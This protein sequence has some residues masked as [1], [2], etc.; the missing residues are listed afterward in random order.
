MDQAIGTVATTGN[1][2]AG[3]RDPDADVDNIAHPQSQTP[4][5]EADDGQ[6]KLITLAVDNMHCGGCMRSIERALAALPSVVSARANL[7]QRRVVITTSQPQDIDTFIG[8]LHSEGFSA[9]AIVGHQ[10]EPMQDRMADLSRRLGVAAFATMNVML[11][12]VSVWSGT[13]GDMNPAVQ[14]L[15]HWLSALIALPTIVY[16]GQPFF[17][18]AFTALSHGRVNMDVPIAIGVFLTAALSLYQTQIHGDQVYFDAALMLLTF[19]LMGRLLDQFVRSRAANAASNLLKLRHNTVTAVQADGSH[20][21]LAL[22]DV[23]PGLKVLVAVG[24]RIS[25]DGR[26]VSGKSDVDQSLITGES[27]P[28]PVSENGSVFAGTLNL[29]GPLVVEVTAREDQSVLAEIATLLANAEQQRGR[30]VDIADRAARYYAPF[31]H[32][33][34]AATFIG[35]W[36]AAADWQSA[37]P[38][39]IS[40][41][42]ITCPCALALAVPAVQVAASGALLKSGIILKSPDAL[43]RLADCT[44]LVYDKT[45][46]LTHGLPSL[47]DKHRYSDA[48]I[49][50]V[51]ALA[52]ASTHPYAQALVAEARARNLAV[53]LAPDVTEEPGIGLSAGTGTNQKRLCNPRALPQALQPRQ[54][55]SASTVAFQT[56]SLDVIFFQFEDS[57][58]AD[59]ADTVQ[60]LKQNGYT[61]E[62]LSGDNESGVRAVADHLPIDRW[63]GDQTPAEK[64]QYLDHLKQQNQTVAMIGDG[65]NDA[66]SLAS[67]HA[68]MSPASASH[69]SQVAADIVFQG[70]KLMPVAFTLSTAKFAQKLVRQNFALAIGYNIVFVPLAMLGWVTPLVAAI[71]M[72]LSSVSVTANALRMSLHQMEKA[73]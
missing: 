55:Q 38:I 44:T 60:L 64:V 18:S 65:L 7:S 58:K 19:L 5:A 4:P 22:S 72:S 51:A 10:S 27:V 43:E 39:A 54:A 26:I 70:Q 28:Q 50:D 56:G 63:K 41:L 24:E 45:G 9:S 47:K 57:A 29:T 31:V 23:T 8:A 21:T 3:L 68:S 12:S 48:I 37:L 20:E 59:A 33:L 1:I 71:A 30:Y 2:D 67:A 52:V 53:T 13:E 11:L 25:V 14:T 69:I 73:K 40:V 16:S 6:P 46:T 49:A 62:I 32:T 66:P 15:F 42:I 17:S 36:I 61:Q 34:A 35:W